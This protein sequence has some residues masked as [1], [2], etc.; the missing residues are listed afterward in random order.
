MQGHEHVTGSNTV[1]HRALETNGDQISPT[2]A[3]RKLSATNPAPKSRMRR[4]LE[5]DCGGMVPSVSTY[6][7]VRFE[8]FPRSDFPPPSTAQ[9]FFVILWEGKKNA[10]RLLHR[11]IR[12][13]FRSFCI[14]K[15][16]RCIVHPRPHVVH[17]RCSTRTDKCGISCACDPYPRWSALCRRGANANR[18]NVQIRLRSNGHQNLSLQDMQPVRG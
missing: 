15:C 10:L 1:R 7:W 4:I 2:P 9:A 3:F 5:H 18:C 11:R 14:Y 17:S 13:I 6:I 12:G 16:I 8:W